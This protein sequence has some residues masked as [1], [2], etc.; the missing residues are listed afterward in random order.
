VAEGDAKQEQGFI[1]THQDFS[2][3]LNGNQII[4]VIT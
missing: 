2:I 3:G 1:Y 4:E